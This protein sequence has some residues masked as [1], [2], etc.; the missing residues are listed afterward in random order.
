MPELRQN[1]ATKEW[2]VIATER[3]KRPHE[4][5]TGPARTL[6]HERPSFVPNCPFCPGNEHETP[7]EILRWPAEGP[8]RLRVFPNKFAALNRKGARVHCL[9]GLH[10]KLSGVGFHEVLIES[11]LHN[12]TP[13]LQSVEDLTLTLKAFQ[14][15]GREIMDD[16][17]VEQ[18]F[19][20]KNHGASAGTSLEHPH[21]QLLA[22][23]MVPYDVRRRIDELRRTFDDDGVCPIC[24][25][26]EMELAD[27]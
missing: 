1:L 14:T 22:L 11:P 19:Y 13:A 26:I 10:R 5:S 15:R 4:L 9:D 27:Q 2:V 16:P 18:I 12:T 24:Q 6:T 17:R 7:G 25:M 21:C 3:A 8:W 23:P 20:F